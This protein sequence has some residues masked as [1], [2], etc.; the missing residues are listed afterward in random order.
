M[1]ELTPDLIDPDGTAQQL[2]SSCQ[3]EKAYEQPT[4]PQPTVAVSAQHGNQ[5]RP[6]L[7]QC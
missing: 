7:S 6:H 5:P 4:T 2:D 3:K 1:Y